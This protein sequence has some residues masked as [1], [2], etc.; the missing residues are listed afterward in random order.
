MNIWIINHYALTPSQGGLCRHYY[1]AKR[2]IEKG[3]NVRI[4]TSSAIHNTQ[5]NM[6]DK[7]DKTLFK[8]IDVDGL[9]YTYIKS[10]QYTGNGLGRI[11]N[12]L[13]FALNI[14]KVRK[15]YE[16]ENPD[17]IYTSSPDLFTAYFSQKLAKKMNLPNIVEIRDLWP[18]SIVD[19]KNM[20]NCNPIIKVLYGLEK[21][22]YKK[23]DA[24]IFTMPGGKDY[25][26]D[27]KWDKCVSLNKVFNINNGID[28][29]EQEKQ[30]K[31]YIYIDADLA[32]ESTFKVIYAGSIRQANNISNLIGAAQKILEQGYKD[33]K[34]IIFGDGTQ[35][36]A[37]EEKCK[38]ENI[39]N[40]IFKGKV[41]K[42]YIPNIL[43]HSD[44]NI[45]NYKNVNIWKYGG[46]QNKLF[47]YLA[48]GRPVLSTIKMGHSLIA[49]CHCGVELDNQNV[50]TL[51]NAIMNMY[52]LP[53]DD[54][55]KMCR[56]AREAAKNYDFDILT[57]KLIEVINYVM[58]N[59]FKKV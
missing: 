33:I 25:I 43:S 44:L 3:H 50:D 9:T 16:A 31:D 46:S 28:I 1:F 13:S 58:N 45:L 4:I 5:I 17:I 6:I 37:L 11:K 2:L 36:K 41:E 38:R 52:N 23:A 42:K 10:G 49:E 47:E 24:L 34:F 39:E 55:D 35:R 54:Y 18:L 19:Y 21:K 56:N 30:K 12:M 27:K 40:V 53:K 26:V 51:A 48:S 7:G 20:S 22:I 29:N 57:Q 14:A 59:K 32:D 15:Q 8:E